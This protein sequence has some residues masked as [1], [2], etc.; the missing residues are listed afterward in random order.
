VLRADN[1]HVPIVLKS[2]N[3]KLLESSGTVQDCTGNCSVFK[4]FLSYNQYYRNLSRNI[5][6]RTVN[7]LR[8]GQLR[9]P[10]PISRRR[11]RFFSFLKRP[12]RL[13]FTRLPMGPGCSL[14]GGVGVGWVNDLNI[15]LISNI[16]LSVEV[17][18]EWS[19]TST[20]PYVFTM[21]TG[22][23]GTALRVIRD[24]NN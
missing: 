3:L 18:N 16:P 19:C 11:K 5:A 10:F 22:T 23:A 20:S 6:V 12:D 15:N 4:L 9:N 7:K 13:R 2:G 8:A 1:L 17:K 14:P 24:S 21:C